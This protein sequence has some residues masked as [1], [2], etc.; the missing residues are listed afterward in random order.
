MRV[1]FEQAI[2]ILCIDRKSQGYVY[3]KMEY[4]GNLRSR[5]IISFRYA[6]ESLIYAISR[7]VLLLYSEISEMQSTYRKD[8]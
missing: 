5:H 7:F 3:G 8:A 6:D 2:C 1:N 4:T